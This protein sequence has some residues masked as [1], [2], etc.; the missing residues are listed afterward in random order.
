MDKERF[1]SQE[2]GKKKQRK[3]EIL[4]WSCGVRNWTF[5]AKKNPGCWG[6]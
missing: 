3:A 6:T 4:T 2:G 1:L 5:R